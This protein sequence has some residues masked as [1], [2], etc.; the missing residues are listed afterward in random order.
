MSSEGALH[1]VVE[2]PEFLRAA[3]GLLDEAEKSALVDYIA[4]HPSVGDLIVGTGGA[5]KLRWAIGNRGKGEKANLTKAERNELR[6]VLSD[7][8]AIYRKGRER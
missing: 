5:R 4:A 3:Q 6:D 8:A 2:T 1:S 7:I